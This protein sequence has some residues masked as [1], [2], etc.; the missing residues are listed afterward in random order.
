MATL[1]AVKPITHHRPQAR[2]RSPEIEDEPVARR[3]GVP[4]QPP[5]L[6]PHAER[7]QQQPEHD[8]RRQADE[9]DEAGVRVV[10]EPG[11]SATSSAR[12]TTALAVVSRTPASA[13]G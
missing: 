11:S 13:T 4:H 9:D 5:V 2:F 3:A 6:E 10:E 7:N 1:T 12:K 8:E